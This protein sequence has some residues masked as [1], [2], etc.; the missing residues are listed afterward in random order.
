[1]MTPGMMSCKQYVSQS[2]QKLSIVICA[3]DDLRSLF[4]VTFQAAHFVNYLRSQS[5]FPIT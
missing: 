4:H 3:V 5:H 1:M 2:C